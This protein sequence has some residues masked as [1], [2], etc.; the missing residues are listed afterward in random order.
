MAQTFSHLT[1]STFIFLYTF[2]D[3]CI[4]YDVLNYGF[5]LKCWENN[6]DVYGIRRSGRERKE[7]ERLNVAES[8]SSDRGQKKVSG[9]RSSKK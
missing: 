2:Y 5:L 1:L 8:D 9:R 6:P 7:P 3:V 4:L